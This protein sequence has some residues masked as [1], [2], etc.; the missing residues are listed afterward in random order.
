MLTA[1]VWKALLPALLIG[2]SACGPE[3]PADLILYNGNVISLDANDS[4]IQAIAVTNGRITAVGSNES[5]LA[6]VGSETEKI[7]SQIVR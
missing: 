6:Q 2:L 1:N 5:V 3:N 7:E 4:R